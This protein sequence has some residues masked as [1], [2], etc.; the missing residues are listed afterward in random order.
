M[1]G[2]IEQKYLLKVAHFAHLKEY[3]RRNI[4]FTVRDWRDVIMQPDCPQLLKERIAAHALSWDLK[5]KVR[6]IKESPDP[7]TLLRAMTLRCEYPDYFIPNMELIDALQHEVDIGVTFNVILKAIDI[8]ANPERDAGL[9]AKTLRNLTVSQRA[10]LLQRAG[11]A[12]YLV[13]ALQAR[14]II[15]LAE[16]LELLSCAKHPLA[17]VTKAFESYFPETEKEIKEIEEFLKRAAELEREKLKEA[18]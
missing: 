13:D 14:D 4:R 5:L 6:I 1:V 18:E 3:V 10:E 17:V 7:K 2:E 12:D 8:A 16:R 9:L 15:P 11:N